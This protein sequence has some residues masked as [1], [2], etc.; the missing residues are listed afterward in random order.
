MVLEFFVTEL[1][2][3]TKQVLYEKEHESPAF[4]AYKSQ[5]HSV[6]WSAYYKAASRETQNSTFIVLDLS[7][8]Y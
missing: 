7:Q 5:N 4:C 6:E 1:L 2:T 8:M 3:K